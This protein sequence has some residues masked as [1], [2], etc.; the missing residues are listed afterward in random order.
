M[1]NNF[2]STTEPPLSLRVKADLNNAEAATLI[3]FFV[4]IA[5]VAI[6]YIRSNA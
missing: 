6:T 2:N 1:S 3:V 4:C 5:A